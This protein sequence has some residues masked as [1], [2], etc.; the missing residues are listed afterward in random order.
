MLAL[1]KLEGWT[2]R[3]RMPPHFACDASELLPV[4]CSLDGVSYVLSSLGGVCYTFTGWNLL[5]VPWMESLKN[6]GCLSVSRVTC[7]RS[8]DGVSY[9][10]KRKVLC[11]MFTGWSLL[12]AHGIQSLTCSVEGVCDMLTEWSLLHLKWK[13]SAHWMESPMFTGWSPL[14]LKWKVSGVCSLDGV[15]YAHC[16]ECVTSKVEYVCCM[17]TGWSLLCS[18]YGVCYI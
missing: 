1:D 18:L 8:L 10:F 16:M 3:Q 2:E 5:H 12:C 17:L 9:R 6:G 4:T 13:V 7:S 14:H 11:Y 15:S